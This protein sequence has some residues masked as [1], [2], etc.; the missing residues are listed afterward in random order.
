MIIPTRVWYCNCE[1]RN[2]GM[3]YW[4]AVGSI[5]DVE[6]AQRGLN[7]AEHLKMV[8]SPSFYCPTCCSP[9]S[10]EE[11]DASRIIIRSTQTESYLH[12]QEG[13]SAACSTG[14]SEPTEIREVGEERGLTQTTRQR[15]VRFIQMDKLDKFSDGTDCGWP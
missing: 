13:P 1:I 4:I 9:W 10:P 8:V 7:V 15:F 12:L 14:S 11:S 5:L 2:V 6:P 3:A